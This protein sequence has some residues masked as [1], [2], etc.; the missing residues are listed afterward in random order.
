[1]GRR[2]L[3]VIGVERIRPPARGRVEHWDA[4]LPGFGLRVTEN[5]RKSWVLMARLRGE[6]LRYTIGVY[7]TISLSKAR[8]LARS[9]LHL[10]AEGKD[11]RDERKR[12]AEGAKTGTFA[13]VAAAFI[14][15]DQN[16]GTEWAAERARVVNREL[17]P[18]WGTQQIASITRRDVIELLEGIVAR[19]ARIQAN[20]THAVIARLFRWAVN[21]DL[22][23]GSPC[24]GLER[25]GG[26]EQKRERVLSDTELV[27]L[28]H[29][30]DTLA[31]RRGT[32]GARKK[33]EAALPG[34]IFGA[35]LKVLLLVAQ[36]RGEVATMTWV[37]VDLERALW[38]I[39]RT[40]GGHAHEVPL[41]P[42][43]VAILAAIPRHGTSGYVFTTNGRTPISGFGKIAAVVAEEAEVTGWRLHDFRRTAA[44][45]LAALGVTKET[46]RR[47]L[48]HAES[49]VTAT[50]VRFGWIDQKREALERWAR[51]V[52]Q[53][54]ERDTE[55][56]V[57]RTPERT[58][59][60]SE[61]TEARSRGTTRT[62]RPRPRKELR[63]SVSSLACYQRSE[64]SDSR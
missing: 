15:R 57:P 31:D 10:I 9:A 36:R 28:W 20:R 1:M 3:T 46:I 40:K 30:F 43:V 60:A 34:G 58:G 27:S 33:R 51:H 24:V 39:P 32:T 7:P 23:P 56:R 29:A 26:R 5:G 21:Q 61:S 50:Y 42:A 47:V 17:V 38:T 45:N 37:D 44:T 2:T 19:G 59:S 18:A 53:L 35:Y 52:E 48:G 14:A 64:E 13:N 41:A 62:R 25:P 55:R 8:E 12:R 49:D 6:L 54:V 22:A 4:S 63:P 16:A 11:P